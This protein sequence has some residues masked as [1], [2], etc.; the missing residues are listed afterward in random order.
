MRTFRPWSAEPPRP[1]PDDSE[2][3]PE[4]RLRDHVSRITKAKVSHVYK[5]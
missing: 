3:R 4:E 1:T 2:R 5:K